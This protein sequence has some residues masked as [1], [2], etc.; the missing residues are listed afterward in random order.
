MNLLQLERW[1]ATEEACKTYLAKLRWPDGFCCKECKFRQA[2]ITGRVLFHCGKCGTAVSPTSGTIFHRSHIPL[3]LWFR[4]IWW[5]TNQKNGVSALGLQR[6][7][8]LG[9]YKTAWMCLQKLR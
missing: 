7:L 5:V 3:R 4:A 9:S 8:G 1:F 2:W 6:L